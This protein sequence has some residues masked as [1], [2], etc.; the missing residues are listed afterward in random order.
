MTS[1]YSKAG[2][3]SSLQSNLFGDFSEFDLITKDNAKKI[4]DNINIIIEKFG[5]LNGSLDENKTKLQTTFEKLE[6]M[7]LLNFIRLYKKVI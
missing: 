2:L 7:L 3:F 1:E 5:I 6:R 4:S